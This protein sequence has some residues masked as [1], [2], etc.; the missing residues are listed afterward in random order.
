MKYVNEYNSM[1]KFRPTFDAWLWE[2]LT[3]G[4]DPAD[5][6]VVRVAA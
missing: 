3:N 2:R 1:D 4:F 5:D 6:Q